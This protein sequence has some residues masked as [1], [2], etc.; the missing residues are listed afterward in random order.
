MAAPSAIA[1]WVH[2]PITL[3]ERSI[4]ANPPSASWFIPCSI[5]SSANVA[6]VP[7]KVNVNEVTVKDPHDVP[8]ATLAVE[9]E[10]DHVSVHVAD[11]SADVVDARVPSVFTVK[12]NA[13]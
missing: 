6:A 3:P 10:T 5:A 7:F 4:G 11:G 1:T 8:A 12:S 2:V 13:V 9:P